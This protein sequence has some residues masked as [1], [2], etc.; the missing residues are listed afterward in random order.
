MNFLSKFP[1]DIWNRLT[2][3]A[4]ELVNSVSKVQLY[5]TETEIRISVLN[6]LKFPTP[7]AKYWQC[8]REQVMML[9]QLIRV[10]FELR[11]NEVSIKRYIHLLS[12]TRD[13][14]DKELAEIALEECEYNKNKMLADISDRCREILIWSKIKIELNDG[15]FD[16]KNVN[17]HQLIS[18]TVE[19]SKRF[20][21]LGRSNITSGEL[22]NLL[23]QLTTAI[24]HCKENGVYRDVIAHFP[25]S[26]VKNIEQL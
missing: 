16:T 17:T 15:S 18:Y 19:F 3:I 7:A 10:N 20:N 22:D 23:G 1:I 8:I 12:V 14:F 21:L 2:P 13:S 25:D 4:D 6:D 26:Q 11:K 24:K 9:E 5:R